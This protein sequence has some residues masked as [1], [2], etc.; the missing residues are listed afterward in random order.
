VDV[1]VR[2]PSGILGRLERGEV[3]AVLDLRGARPGERLFHLL[4]DEVRVPFGIEVT[5]ITPPTVALTF[6]R[7]SSRMVP[8]VPAIDG[9][10]ATGYVAGRVTVDPAAVEVVGPQSRLSALLEA[11]TEPVSIRNA[12]RRVQDRVTVGVA[13]AALRLR[14]PRSATVTVDILPAP[15]E[16]AV[17][18]VPVRIRNLGPRRRGTASPPRVTLILRGARETLGS[19][20]VRALVAWVDAASLEPGGYALPVRA[21]GGRDFTVA[22]IEPGVVQVRL[23]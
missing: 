1:R 5:Q 16:R 23:R 10:P 17:Y 19:L 6:E 22:R 14:L 7:S 9:E 13:D 20:D 8:V 11:T 3:V 18:D 2:G 4:I 15:I 21:D 12:T